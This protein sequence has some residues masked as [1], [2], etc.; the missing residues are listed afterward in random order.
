MTV[1]V[2]YSVSFRL[3]LLIYN[4]DKKWIC[5]RNKDF[6]GKASCTN[7]QKRGKE[8]GRKSAYINKMVSLVE[9][10]LS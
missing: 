9:Q 1:T 5:Q 10:L 7:V 8:G 3:K 2:R 6:K 4:T